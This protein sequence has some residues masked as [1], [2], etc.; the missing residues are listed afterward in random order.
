MKKTSGWLEKIPGEALLLLAAVI[1][2]TGFV[3]QRKAMDS[4]QPFA[5]IAM[6]FLLGCLVLLPGVILTQK[7]KLPQTKTT[8]PWKEAVRQNI[9]PGIV[10]GFFLFAGASM[11]QLG[12]MTTSAAK[13]GFITSLYLVLVPL[14]GLFFG[15]RVNEWVWVGVAIA[16]MGVF[17]LS[18]DMELTIH[19]GDVL[20]I[21]G[22]FFWAMQI[23]S[24]D[25]FS[26]YTNSLSLAFGQFL[27]T[28]ILGLVFSLAIEGTALFSDSPAWGPLLYS[29]IFAVGIGF[30]LQVFG[31]SKVNPTLASLIMSLEAV[32]AM[33][34]GMLFLGEQL[35][36]RECLG[37]LLM[38]AAVVLVQ[39]K[40]QQQKSVSEEI[41]AHKIIEPDS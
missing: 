23:L 30:T 17:Y 37:G 14:I 8:N 19:R 29:G 27:T 11:Q 34:S 41:T 4:M 26:A 2:G 9:L 18:V 21:I 25:H 10:P 20:M 38:M 32:F 33:I 40:G 31:Q 5:F 39:L 22:A 6:R 28:A 15:K 3:A 1:W 7:S 12:I 13:A 24:L 35:T 36:A 16:L